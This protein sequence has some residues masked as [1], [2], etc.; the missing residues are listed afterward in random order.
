MSDTWDEAILRIVRA[1]A[2]P[3]SLP[4]IYREMGK[5][6]LVTAH[7]REPWKDGVPNYHHAIRRRL[8]DLCNRGDV[9][10]VGRGIYT[11]N[12]S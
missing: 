6:P 11:S 8:T 3:L 7:H 2:R 5:S 10:R 12:R 1:S 9:R 4:E